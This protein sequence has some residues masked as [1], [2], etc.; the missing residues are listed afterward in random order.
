M[1][2]ITNFQPGNILYAANLNTDYAQAVNIAGDA[3]HGTLTVPNFTSNVGIN[4]GV[5]FANTSVAI[6]G[7]DIGSGLSQAQANANSALN[8]AES[9]FSTANAGAGGF[10]TAAFNQANSANIL[11]QA[12]FNQ[13]NSANILAQAAF[14]KANTG[15]GS[16]G[17]SGNSLT[18]TFITANGLTVNNAVTFTVVGN[19][20]VVISAN[21]ANST[22]VGTVQLNDTVVS[23]STTLA[24]TANAVN[25]TWA[26]AN[27]AFIAANAVGAS[28]LPNLFVAA[29]VAVNGISSVIISG[30]TQILIQ[31]NNA[32]TTKPGLVILNDTIT[33]T[34]TTLAATAN[35]VNAVYNY[36]QAQIGKINYPT[37]LT[38]TSSNTQFA[39]AP[40]TV[41][42]TWTI[43]PLL[44]YATDANGTIFF[45]SG[46]TLP[47]VSNNWSYTNPPL[48]P[49]NHTITVIDAVSGAVVTQNIT[50]VSV[51]V[52]N[53]SL[54]GIS[55]TNNTARSFTAPNTSIG[56]LVPLA[57]GGNLTGVTFSIAN[58]STAGAFQLVSGNVI[59]FL[60][61]NVQPG[62]YT[63]NVNVS[64]TNAN[65]SPQVYPLNLTIYTYI[66]PYVKRM[67]D[68]L[69]MIGVRGD[70]GSLASIYTSNSANVVKDFQFVG[71]RNWRDSLAATSSATGL[72][73]LQALAS[74]GAAKFLMFVPNTGTLTPQT[75]NVTQLVANCAT[76]AAMAAN[77]LIAIEGPENAIA[78]PIN[79]KGNTG[80]GPS[81][82]YF[83]VANFQSDFFTAINANN[84]LAPINVLSPTEVGQ[85]N[86]NVGLQYSMIPVGSGVT[87]FPANTSYYDAENIRFYPNINQNTELSYST[88][89]GN[90]IDS[91]LKNDFVKTIRNG[92]SGNS[93]NYVKASQRYIAEYG[94]PTGTGTAVTDPTRGKL[95]LNTLFNAFLDQYKA[96][97]IY[98]LYDEGGGTG[99]MA[100]AGTPTTSGTYL[101]NLTTIL[102]DN[103]ANAAT[104]VPG[105]LIYSVNGLPGTGRTAAFQK[106][107]GHYVLA[108]WNNVHDYNLQSNTAITV[109]AVNVQ[110]TFGTSNAA[111][112]STINVYDPTLGTNPTSQN[113]IVNVS[114]VTIALTDYPILIDLTPLTNLSESA[115][116]TTIVAANA[117]T[118][119]I[120]DADLNVWN[121][122]NPAQ[123]VILNGNLLANTGSVFELLYFDHV[124]YQENTSNAWWFWNGATWVATTNPVIPPESE[125][126]T[127]VNSSNYTFLEIGDALGN[128]WSLT[129]GGNNTF[130]IL[131]NGANA[132][133]PSNNVTLLLYWNHVVYQEN[134]NGIWYYWNDQVWVQGVDPRVLPPTANVLSA[135]VLTTAGNQIVD[136]SVSQNRICAA[137]WP[138]AH[139][140]NGTLSLLN[141]NSYRTIL[142]NLKAAGFNA[143]KIPTADRQWINNSNVSNIVNTTLNPDLAANQSYVGVISTIINWGYANLGLRFIIESRVNE[144]GKG[145][146]DN[147][148]S[149]QLNGLWY[150]SGGAS[151]GTDGGDNIGTI[152]DA[153]FV[154]TWQSRATTFV[155]NLGVVG[156]HLRAQPYFSLAGG[157]GSTSPGVHW[158]T[159]GGGSANDSTDI[160]SVYQ[161]AGN[162][163]QA[164]D[165]TKLIICEAP[166]NQTSTLSGPDLRGI[167]TAPV[168]LTT[169]NKVVYAVT[170]YPSDVTGSIQT[171][172]GASYVSGLNTL[173]GFVVFNNQAPVLVSDLGGTLLMDT[174]AIN[175]MNSLIGYMNGSGNTGGPTLV[176]SQQGLGWSWWAIGTQNSG[177]GLV[178]ND[179]QTVNPVQESYY[180]QML[181]TKPP[182]R[183]V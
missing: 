102:A 135:G 103:S 82:S 124:V 86:E 65:N 175:N 69:S 12:A 9:A 118:T 100:A 29:N 15:N 183:T 30:N 163:I 77:C 43:N 58:Q 91:Q 84:T 111:F 23:Q 42:G 11:A 31:G 50:V 148:G 134:V 172:S 164:I 26:T 129:P 5:I 59:Q 158:N 170:L 78:W 39:N 132:L 35:S 154:S 6:N 92:W 120:V 7:V 98:Q 177:Y 130:Q 71:A 160:W 180:S 88:V 19:N 63:V 131:Q 16:G 110:I 143:V 169:A 61:N 176:G 116:L 10:A 112:L 79:Y 95:Y 90:I 147:F 62:N 151:D 24:A 83:A 73:V 125:T 146:L 74:N 121:L 66:T 64:A 155:G 174:D 162:A 181:Y 72:G 113:N 55:I 106:S 13:A 165:N 89:N 127:I 168:V 1:P 149:Y 133:S 17:S 114:S 8:L 75:L 18:Q 117:N 109:N 123:Q 57:T 136:S 3:M 101:H 37:V 2:V 49:G 40:F 126:D 105:Q 45:P 70:I 14:N 94:F 80:G 4:T 137:V 138:G 150:D 87:L 141:T 41:T 161:R 144:G 173:W 152:T 145:T 21:L 67:N 167:N 25:T 27:A 108:V 96:V 107:N 99:L 122:A 115:S 28:L 36:A 51:A 85:E 48:L 142:T 32:T 68:F 182:L 139:L 46:N 53:I 34:S 157:L 159:Y 119:Q 128:V 153:T 140:A 52:S 179:G 38:I 44:Q 104:V 22:T 81:G 47:L 166:Q 56:T 54:T 93:F 97:S 33:S 178:N 156:Y 60:A 76:V 171:D 20:I